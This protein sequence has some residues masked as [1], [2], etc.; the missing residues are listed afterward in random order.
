MAL[1]GPE[2]RHLSYW[3]TLHPRPFALTARTARTPAVIPPQ[4]YSAP[5]IDPGFHPR[6]T[7]APDMTTSDP[8][9][10]YATFATA[11]GRGGP[12]PEPPHSGAL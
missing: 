4:Q 3:A 7:A 11:A 10:P 8:G 1:P 5:V 6:T 9:Q 2:E 12:V